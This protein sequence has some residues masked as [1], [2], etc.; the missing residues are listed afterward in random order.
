[1]NFLFG[2]DCCSLDL[3]DDC[4]YFIAFAGGVP[5]KRGFGH[6]K[7][8]GG[9]SRAFPVL[10]IESHSTRS[11]R[12]GQ[13][14]GHPAWGERGES[15]LARLEEGRLGGALEGD[16]AVGLAAGPGE[17]F[18]IG[19]EFGVAVD[20]VEDSGEDGGGDGI[21]GADE[22]IVHPLPFPAGGDDTGFAEV[23]EMAGDFRLALAEDFD[24]VANAELA[25]GD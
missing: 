11:A 24:E 4:H 15:R 23:G 21:A 10:G 3:S 1:V 7:F 16:E 5:A 20:G 25:A 22:A 17:A 12:S 2:H 8:K 9:R 19:L 13:A 14:P 18:A 6:Q